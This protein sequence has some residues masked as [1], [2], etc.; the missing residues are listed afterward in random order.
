MTDP[1]LL[2]LAAAPARTTAVALS[3]LLPMLVVLAGPTPR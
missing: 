2:H 3:A 1:L